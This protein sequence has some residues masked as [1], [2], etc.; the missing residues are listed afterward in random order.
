MHQAQLIEAVPAFYYLAFF[1]EPK[2]G[3]PGYCNPIAGWGGPSEL[4]LVGA[5]SPPA[6]NYL[7]SLGYLVFY[8]RMKV[9]EC[10]AELADEPLD[11]LGP[12][13]LCMAVRLMGDVS[14]EDLIH[15]IQLPLLETSST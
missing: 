7:V 2:D 6:G 12:T 5:A 3:C 13:L 11:I 15:H 14:T 4:T 1:R 8:S 9:G 10:L